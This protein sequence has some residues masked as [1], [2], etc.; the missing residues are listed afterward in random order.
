MSELETAAGIDG[1][2]RRKN[3]SPGGKIKKRERGE[4]FLMMASSFA[5]WRFGKLGKRT[6][7]LQG[8][9]GGRGLMWCHAVFPS[10]AAIF[11]GR[12]S[13]VLSLPPSLA[14]VFW[15]RFAELLLR[16][17]AAAAA[18]YWKNVICSRRRRRR[19]RDP[20]RESVHVGS[21]GVG[22]DEAQYRVSPRS[23]QFLFVRERVDI[24]TTDV[25]CK[26]A[27]PSPSV[28]PSV[29]PSVASVFSRS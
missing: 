8:R 23:L 9:E 29:R 12:K 11:R 7:W 20:P 19:Q 13:V 6:N 18:D 2:S 24:R 14:R 15:V 3:V 25:I 5:F 10:V 22:D 17:A 27:P 21:G 28:R 4:A 1:T 16:S 26:R